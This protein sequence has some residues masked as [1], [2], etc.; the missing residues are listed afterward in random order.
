M[1]LSFF[2]SLIH[3]DCDCA[4]SLLGWLVELQG[5]GVPEISAWFL[6]KSSQRLNVNQ[7]WL[8]C[9]P[10]CSLCYVMRRL[11][12]THSLAGQNINRRW[13][14]S[15]HGH[16]F[17]TRDVENILYPWHTVL[18]SKLIEILGI[19]VGQLAWYNLPKSKINIQSL[20]SPHVIYSS[21]FTKCTVGSKHFFLWETFRQFRRLSDSSRRNTQEIQ[22]ESTSAL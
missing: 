22:K 15:G 9:W 13:R 17:G 14:H 7:L 8:L 19:Y 1:L 5:L 10:C 6:H 20:N 16:H 3:P 12:G 18:G 4:F 21:Y 2:L 11:K